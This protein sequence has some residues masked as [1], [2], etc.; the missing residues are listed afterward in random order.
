MTNRNF[1][2]HT[3]CAVLFLLY[4]PRILADQLSMTYDGNRL[5]KIDNS[6]GLFVPIPSTNE[7]FFT[8]WNSNTQTD[9]RYNVNGAMIKDVNRGMTVD[10]NLLNLPQTL[11]INNP[12]TEGNTVYSYSA[13]GVKRSVSHQ[14]HVPSALN[15][16]MAVNSGLGKW[17]NRTTDYIGNKTYVNGQLDK[18]LLPNGYIKNGRYHFYLRDHL[19]NNRVVMTKE[20]VAIGTEPAD[21]LITIPSDSAIMHNKGTAS[22]LWRIAAVQRT[23]Y[24]PSG[25]PFPNMLNPQEQPYKYNGK[26]FDTMHGLNMYDY[27]AR[28]YDAAI[29]R[30]HVPDALAE[31]Y[32]SISPYAYCAN[33][34]VKF[35]D[36]DGKE[37]RIGSLVID[38]DDDWV[39]GKERNCPSRAILVTMPT[40]PN[41]TMAKATRMSL[42]DGRTKTT[43]CMRHS[44]HHVATFAVHN[45]VSVR[46][47]LQIYSGI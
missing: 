8:D 46:F 34:P 42:A 40:L 1:V 24:Y 26:E 23:D 3:I 35:I 22:Y 47:F 41:G 6:T 28:H 7:Y 25:L 29:M 36:P 15:S 5:K 45:A 14:W 30:W 10:Y 12:V 43:T 19:G 16:M 13:D 2:G 38:P 18:I 17:W 33:N 4:T 9:Y 39:F 27:G 21:S 31:E 32:Y 11:S 37:V 20:R 44:Y